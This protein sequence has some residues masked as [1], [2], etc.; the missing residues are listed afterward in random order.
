MTLGFS[1]QIKDK[2][3]F[4]VEKILN[5]IIKNSLAVVDTISIDGKM[6][7]ALKDKF[8]Q[9]PPKTHTIRED[10][11]NR[12][13]V[14]NDIHFV[15]NNR[16]KNRFQFA[17]ILKVTNIN[18]IAF[19]WDKGKYCQFNGKECHINLEIDKDNVKYGSAEFNYKNEITKCTDW[20]IE[21]AKNDGFDSIE[22]FFDWFKNDFEGKLISWTDT[23]Y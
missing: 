8:G 12:W 22:D 4:F 7:F 16:T 23:R 15:I 21:L 1:T 6:D 18:R 20:I 10:K 19:I 13:K 11:Y 14:G 3:T 5:S 2:P 9:L 17:P